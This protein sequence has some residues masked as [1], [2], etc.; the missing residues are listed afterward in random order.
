MRTTDAGEDH[1]DNQKGQDDRDDP[2]HLHPTWGAGGRSARGCHAGVALLV[3]LTRPVPGHAPWLAH[4]QRR[5][6]EQYQQAADG[7]GHVGKSVADPLKLD[8]G[9]RNIS[10]ASLSSRHITDGVKRILAT[11]ETVLK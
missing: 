10:G 4:R 3:L 1:D 8:V 5:G 11:Y 2:E 7:V 9:I 6:Q